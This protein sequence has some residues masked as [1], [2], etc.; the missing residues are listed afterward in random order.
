MKAKL[1][2]G[3]AIT[4]TAHKLARILWAMI[5]HR[6]PYD[7]ARLGNPELRLKRKEHALRRAAK[8]LGYVLQP[9]QTEHVC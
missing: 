4:A 8:E 9:T 5:K 6:Q 2:S 3:G 1:G 7:R